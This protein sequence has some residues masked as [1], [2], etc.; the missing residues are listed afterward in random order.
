MR[1]KATIDR[2]Y[3]WANK[4]RQK[5]QDVYQM[6]GSPSAM[7]TFEKYDDICDICIAAENGVAEEDETRKHIH[8]NQMAVIDRLRDMR[9]VAP[10]KTF[11]YA[12]VEEWMRKMMV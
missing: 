7:R 9:S 3:K 8:N 10:S 2:I 12:D 11:S 1:D 6:S 5:Y 4:N